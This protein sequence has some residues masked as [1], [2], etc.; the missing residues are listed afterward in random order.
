MEK[1]NT[2]IIHGPPGVGKFTVAKSLAQQTGYKLIHIHTLYDFL[3]D[4]FTRDNY[5]VIL[6]IINKVYLSI[7]QEA[8]KLG[9]RGVIITYAEIARD[10]FSFVRELK[11]MLDTNN[12]ELR[13]V[14]LYCDEDELEKRVVEESRKE[15]KKTHT[16]E[17]L[18]DFVSRKNY[19]AIYLE[20]ETL[21]IDNT[22]LPPAE[23]SHL[24][25]DRFSI[26]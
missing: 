6:G 9:F 22:N 1:M 11:R 15:F 26:R 19:E 20:I 13:A 16:V 24:I 12:G 23:A 14:R 2:I 21:N 3:E 5:P 4:I 25:V 10:D 8:A 7:L 17:E 18:R